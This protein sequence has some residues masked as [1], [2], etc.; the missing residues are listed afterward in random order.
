MEPAVAVAP[1]KLVVIGASAGGLNALIALLTHL[2]AGFPLPIVVVQHLDPHHTSSLAPIL[3]RRST[4]RVKP[5]APGEAPHPG[6]VYVAPPD[7]HLMIDSGGRFELDETP[8][9]HFVRPCVDRLFSSAAEH[10]GRVIGVVLS[11]SGSD[12]AQGAQAISRRDGIVVV[13]D[14]ATAA[15]GGMPQATI[16]TGVADY[17]IPLAEIPSLLV[18]LAAGVASE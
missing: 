6:I 7:R 10:L 8:P 9:V 16:D 17:V 15:F 3:D 18:R 12:G 4:I 11:G 2:P 5:A 1:F 13:E 14:A